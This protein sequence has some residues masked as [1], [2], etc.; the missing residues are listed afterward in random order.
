MSAL[1]VSHSLH[2]PECLGVTLRFFAAR[3]LITLTGV[4]F[5]TCRWNAPPAVVHPAHCC[6]MLHLLSY[7]PGVTYQAVVSCQALEKCDSDM[8]CSDAVSLTMS[9]GQ[10]F[11][12]QVYT[13]SPHMRSRHAVEMYPRRCMGW[14]ASHPCA[15][16]GT[17][18]HA[19]GSRQARRVTTSSNAIGW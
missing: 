13:V 3:L 16:L 10:Q 19:C 14:A 2:C 11:T 1:R 5:R 18:D 8:L 9:G 4:C 6:P 17:H 15:A 12:A 7:M